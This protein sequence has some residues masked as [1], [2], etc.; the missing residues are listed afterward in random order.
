MEIDEYAPKDSML[1]ALKVNFNDESLIAA[2]KDIVAYL[3]TQQLNRDNTKV[4]PEDVLTADIDELVLVPKASL[5]ASPR[6]KHLILEQL[7]HIHESIGSEIE[8][9]LQMRRHVGH[10]TKVERTS[11]TFNC[12][13]SP[14]FQKFK[15]SK[16]VIPTSF[17]LINESIATNVEQLQAVKQILAGPSTLAPYIVFGPPGTGKTT[18]IVEAILQL[19]SPSS[20]KRIIVTA[21]SNSAC[22]TIGLRI[23]ECIEK[24]ERFSYDREM[25]NS[26]LLRVFSDSR[27]EKDLKLVHPLVL[28]N[29]NYHHIK[30]AKQGI[31]EDPI[32]LNEYGIIVATLCK[33]ACMARKRKLK[34]V[35]HIF[36]DEA[37]ASSEPESLLGIVHLKNRDCHVILSGDHKQLG[38]VIK[39]KRASSLGLGQSLMGRLMD[40]ELY[41]VDDS[42]NYDCTLQT[43]LRR[44]YRSHPEIVGLF[45]KLYYNNELVPLAPLERIN[46]AANWDLLPNA[47]FPI[48]FQATYGKTERQPLSFS[49]YNEL[50]AEVLCWFVWILLKK[51]LGN[52]SKVEQEDI[53]VISP[54]LAQCAL[55]SK[56]LRQRVSASLKTLSSLSISASCTDIF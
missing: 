18:T 28:R 38:P 14:D 9:N 22:D 56:K 52:G 46:Q 29:S 2:E 15:T 39:S 41:K 19:Y 43:R 53:G 27:S 47:Q 42:G 49:S 48:L 16:V 31:E 11:V 40:S 23:C 6:P 1:Q 7:P 12:N 51:G 36:I 44:N 37:A 4:N 30:N 10:I 55:L 34:N 54:Y 50:E 8:W 35:K 21:G 24:D 13:S 45:N 26:I 33:V 17:K 3:Q 20:N 32:D 25:S 5:L